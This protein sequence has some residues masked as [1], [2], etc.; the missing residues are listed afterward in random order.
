M[1]E[2]KACA[3]STS[4]MKLLLIFAFAAIAM[5]YEHS[6][7]TAREDIFGD[8]ATLQG[9]GSLKN[10]VSSLRRVAPAEFRGHVDLISQHTELIQDGKKAKA[11]AHNFA[12][13]KKAIVGA[14]KALHGELNVGH[15]H[16]KSVPNKQRNL[17][18]ASIKK[19]LK[20]G[21]TTVAKYRNKA[22]PTK[23]L[24]IEANNEKKKAKKQ[25]EQHESKKVCPLGTRFKDM[26]IHKGTPKLGTEL[27]NKWN[28]A[29]A[30]Y[31]KLQ[32]VFNKAA[33][34]HNK[35]VRRYNK[36]MSQF[37]TS[38]RLEAANAHNTCKNARGEYAALVKE[39]ANNVNT[40]KQ[41]YIAT[42]VI[43][44]YINNLTSNGGA[45]ACADKAKRANTAK[46]NISAGPLIPCNS[47]ATNQKIFGPPNWKPT[48][49]NCTL[50][51]WHEALHKERT[52][53]ER[54]AKERVKKEK[55]AKKAER[56]AKERAA[57]AER[58]A[59]EQADKREKKAKELSKKEKA[60]KAA[61]RRD[62]AKKREL[63]AKAD[64]RR[65]KELAAKE[66][67]A[68]E[69]NNKARERAAKKERKAKE[70]E[71]KRVAAERASKERSAKVRRE[72]AQKEQ[73]VKE[74]AK[75][76]RNNKERVK[77]EQER[78]AKRRAQL[79]RNG[80]ESS[81][82]RERSGKVER[83]NKAAAHRERSNKA[84]ER[85]NKAA[86]QERN[87]K[88]ARERNSKNTCHVKMYQHSGYR[89]RVEYSGSFCSGHRQDIRIRQYALGGRRRGY[90]GSSITL[91]RGCRQVQ[92]W[93]ED[94][95]R[96][97]Y[98]HNKNIHH[99]LSG[100]SY[101]LND[102]VCAISVWSKCRL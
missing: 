17:L 52:N 26:D 6:D 95:C 43:K 102:D 49:K 54:R 18:N 34:K 72:K 65:S 86:Q 2:E 88:A 11:Y 79:E 5:A 1:G 25:M 93:D 12:A 90:H 76:E 91:S 94:A 81:A 27:R 99:S 70:K 61:E 73:Q 35:A 22:C 57:K 55:A 15:R 92:L 51:H 46:F 67:Q 68:K 21:K 4:D 63:K 37:R 28:R 8:M 80:K 41:T 71:Q 77:K 64:E 100:F 75:K 9:E 16:D 50:R 20:D 14:I 10:A 7:S 45:K 83:S 3:R 33:A 36:A 31:V 84:T 85:R 97:N 74:R 60:K 59:K 30:V 87:N 96:Y 89:G 38:L 19:S 69:R 56:A 82:K 32:A 98:G 42:L 44:C 48:S 24:E 29:R 53:K 13:S 66:R 58:R 47:K 40:R 78:E 101:D 23:R 39:V 62:K